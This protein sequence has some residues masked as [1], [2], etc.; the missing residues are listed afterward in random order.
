VIFGVRGASIYKDRKVRG[1]GCEGVV[2][3]RS[4][5]STPKNCPQRTQSGSQRSKI[6]VSNIQNSL[7]LQLPEES[8]TLNASGCCS[9]RKNLHVFGLSCLGR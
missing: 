9:C 3:E 8:P 2:E 1:L 4:P 7:R 6:G 5:P